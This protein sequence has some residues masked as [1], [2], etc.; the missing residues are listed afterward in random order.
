M[1]H[2]KIRQPNNNQIKQVIMQSFVLLVLFLYQLVQAQ[3]LED[4]IIQQESEYTLV[5]F[6]YR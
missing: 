1:W 6:S 2:I 4:I 5:Y 3:S